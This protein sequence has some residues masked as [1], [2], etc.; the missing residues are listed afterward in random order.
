MDE[1][2]LQSDLVASERSLA[3]MSFRPTSS[4]T[5]RPR[6]TTT[7]RRRR[8]G[9]SASRRIARSE[10]KWENLDVLVEQ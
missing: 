1:W 10:I 8:S 3:G 2:E 7:G 5:R 6:P 9:L 4:R